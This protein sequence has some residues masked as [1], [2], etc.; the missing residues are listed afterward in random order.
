MKVHHLT[1]FGLPVW[2]ALP[3]DIPTRFHLH[4]HGS[5]ESGPGFEQLGK[6]GLT[7]LILGGL[8][9]ESAVIVPVCPAEYDWRDQDMILAAQ[10]AS[11]QVME[12]YGYRGP[13]SISGYSMGARGVWR[14]LGSK[15]YDRALIVSGRVP[16]RVPQPP[17]SGVTIKIFHGSEDNHEPAAKVRDYCHACRDAGW[18]TIFEELSGAGHYI[19]DKVFSREDV[20]QFISAK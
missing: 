13:V 12:R 10:S 15:L 11:R 4:L 16:P 7:R 14:S 1:N 20:V 19:A 6:W 9:L 2:L 17:D 5:G 8:D 3:Q 18:D